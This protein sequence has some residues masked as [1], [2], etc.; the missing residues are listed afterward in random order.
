ME[1]FPDPLGPHPQNLDFFTCSLVLGPENHSKVSKLEFELRLEPVNAQ[2][3]L[4]HLPDD[5]PVH[6]G[7][8]PG[9]ARGGLPPNDLNG[10]QL[11]GA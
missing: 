10:H 1:R 2:L 5:P 8:G 4:G 3:R 11:C 7:G 6:V 9:R